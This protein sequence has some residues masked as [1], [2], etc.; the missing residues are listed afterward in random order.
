[1]VHSGFAVGAMVDEGLKLSKSANA[2]HCANATD[3]VEH[4]CQ[5]VFIFVQLHFIFIHSHS[6]V[7]QHFS[8]HSCPLVDAQYI[9][10]LLPS[11]AAFALTRLQY[12]FVICAVPFRAL[13]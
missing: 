2:V 6:Q 3:A 4:I 10:F 12:A 7:S 5:I 8:L 11:F 9:Y 13:M 1:M